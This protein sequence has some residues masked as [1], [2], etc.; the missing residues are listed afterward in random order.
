MHQS[1]RKSVR[2]SNRESTGGFLMGK[3]ITFGTLKGGVGKT[4][5][6]FNI[7]GILSQ[8]GYRVLVI[9][10]DLQGNLTNNM[11]IDRTQPDLL[12][13]YDVYNLEEAQP[14][15][16]QLVIKSP[17]DRLPLL[18]M[19]A[20]SIFL[21]KSEL[22]IASVAGREQ[23]LSNYLSDHKAFFDQYD[24]ILIDT[25]PSMSIVNQNAFLAS[26]AILLVSDVSMNAI[27]GAQLFIALWEEARKRL[28]REDNIKGFIVNDFDSRNKLSAD[29]LEY[30]RT[31]PDTED[32]RPI[33]FETVIPR[34]VRITESEL[35]AVPIS[36]YDLRSKGCDAIASLVDEMLARG[37]L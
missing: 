3:I 30:L 15:P 9:D 10:S 23:I 32:L 12:T 37:V 6:C 13:T 34:N 27:E 35:A 14:E 16:D 25:N 19:I 36:I 33:L 7:G 2:A 22:K 17:I 28:R 5:L 29:Y 24:Y 8:L 21:H 11:G 26:D 1:N 31:S 4:M 18:D 20:G